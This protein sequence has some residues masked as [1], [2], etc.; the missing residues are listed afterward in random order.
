LPSDSAFHLLA[1][2]ADGKIA[3]DFNNLHMSANSSAKGMKLDQ[4]INGGASATIQIQV[5]KG[6]IKIAEANP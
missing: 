6:D 3:N 2:A 1:D 5:G 4:I